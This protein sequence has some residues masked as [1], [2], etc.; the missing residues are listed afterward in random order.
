[1]VLASASTPVSTSLP[2]NSAPPHTLPAFIPPP[3]WSHFGPP[4]GFPTSALLTAPVST[5]TPAS[6]HPVSPSASPPASPSASPPASPS[7]L[8]L[9]SQPAT[10]ASHAPTSAGGSHI[11]TGVLIALSIVGVLAL[12]CLLAII[13]VYA[14]RRIQ[15][16]KRAVN[17]EAF[18][19]S[20]NPVTSPPF[21]IS[22]LSPELRST[23]AWLARTHATSMRALSSLS[24][25][26]EAQLRLSDIPSD[27]HTITEAGRSISRNNSQRY[28]GSLPGAQP[29]PLPN[30]SEPMPQRQLQHTTGSDWS[31]PST[32]PPAYSA[33]EMAE[34][35]PDI[36]AGRSKQP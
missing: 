29:Q 4:A 11:S 8:P 24:F 14:R 23:E 20:G 7:T 5:T 31:H 34:S 12:S 28:A 3:F 21:D 35:M 25:T 18:A 17:V 19:A 22:P 15:A 30:R 27:L 2:L 9:V 32:P 13:I 26:S 36:S 1:M 16:R 6:S 33:N 10:Q